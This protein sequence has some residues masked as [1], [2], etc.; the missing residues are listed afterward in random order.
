MIDRHHPEPEDEAAA[1]ALRDPSYYQGL[2]A[3]DEKLRE[4]FD[5]VWQQEYLS[6]VQGGKSRSWK[7]YT[8][9]RRT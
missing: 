9:N 5:P 1:D 3:Y 7:S 4:K 2:V 8:S 6:E